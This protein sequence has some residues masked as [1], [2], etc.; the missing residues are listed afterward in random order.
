MKYYDEDKM[1]N[2][3]LKIEEELLSWSDVTTRKMYGCPC[4]KN[5]EKMFAFLVTDGIVL[6][7][8][9]EKDKLDLSKK[10]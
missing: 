6:T 1:K 4:Y 3:R 7:K 5:K 10:I 9:S 2:I 8:P